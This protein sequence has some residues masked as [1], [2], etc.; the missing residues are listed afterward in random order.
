MVRSMAKAASGR[1]APRYG[2][3]GTLLVATIRAVAAKF[4]ILYG[5]KQ[6]N[7]GV[8]GDRGPYRIPRSAINEEL[9]Q[10]RRWHD[11]LWR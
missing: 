2:A 1:P 11:V 4:A 7:C 3:F 10:A 9:V 6:M 5:T 8:V